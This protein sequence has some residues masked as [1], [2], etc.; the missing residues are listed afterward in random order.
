[1]D[2]L[3][4]PNFKMRCVA[5]CILCWIGFDLVARA[6][7]G[8]PQAVQTYLVDIETRLASETSIQDGI[9]TIFDL[10]YKYLFAKPIADYQAG[11]GSA[12]LVGYQIGFLRGKDGGMLVRLVAV[13]GDS[14]EVFRYPDAS[15]NEVI[16]DG[17][18]TDGI[19][20]AVAPN[21]YLLAMSSP[22][23]RNA[24]GYVTVR[25]LDQNFHELLAYRDTN[26]PAE[27]GIENDLFFYDV[28]GDG[29]KEVLVEQRLLR[30]SL[31]QKETALYVLSLESNN[32]AF[33]DVTIQYEDQL[34]AIF[35][36]AK[37]DPSTPKISQEGRPFDPSAFSVPGP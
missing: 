9:G 35:A 16:D 2:S 19:A 27:P 3:I 6:Q 22:G 34:A 32:Q 36:A 15:R 18:Y 33:T 31:G 5:F 4:N 28:N 20:V 14:N 12:W 29:R 8:V 17:F 11:Q 24:P 26:F 30:Y 21:V 7:E 10:D 25:T 13:D 1:M 37:G 23:G